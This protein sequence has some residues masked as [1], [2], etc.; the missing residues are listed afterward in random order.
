MIPNLSEAGP[1]S[2]RSGDSDDLSNIRNFEPTSKS[3]KPA[4]LS[5]RPAAKFAD[6][7]HRWLKSKTGGGVDFKYPELL[8]VH[9]LLSEGFGHFSN[10]HFF[11][12]N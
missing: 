11:K 10:Y 3:S 5:L 2:A 1:R 6:Q 7:I 9:M 12:I 8:N 4:Y